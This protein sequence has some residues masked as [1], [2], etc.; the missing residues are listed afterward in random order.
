MQKPL[1]PAAAWYF[2]SF[3]VL[4]SPVGRNKNYEREEICGM[5]KPDLYCRL[6]FNRQDENQPTK[7]ASLRDVS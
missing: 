2:S 6:V 5:R 7:D 4:V 3:V 1:P